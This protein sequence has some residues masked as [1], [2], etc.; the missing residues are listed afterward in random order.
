MNR[1]E[2]LHE[3]SAENIAEAVMKISAS[4][5]WKCRLCIYDRRCNKGADCKTGIQR[6]FTVDDQTGKD[7]EK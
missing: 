5:N 7:E 6:F 3:M 2:K 4:S 1:I